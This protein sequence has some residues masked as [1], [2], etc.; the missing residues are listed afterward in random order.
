MYEE[1]T[2]Q[3]MREMASSLRASA[4]Q[5]D[6]AAEIA[7]RNSMS[8]I[9]TRTKMLKTKYIPVIMTSATLSVTDAERQAYAKRHKIPDRNIDRA[10]VE[11][12]RYRTK[13][14]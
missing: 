11:R 5:I 12:K 2:I 7:E 1:T 14:K 4:A 3:D 13:K 8:S 6:K 9:L 10:M